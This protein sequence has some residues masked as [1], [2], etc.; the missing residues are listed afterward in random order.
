MGYVYLGQVNLEKWSG[1]RP[2]QILWK[3]KKLM[4]ASVFSYAG[5]YVV[6]G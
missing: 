6:I 3:L 4:P 5:K 2:M 1:S